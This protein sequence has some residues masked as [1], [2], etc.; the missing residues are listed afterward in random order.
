MSS[1][2]HY[3]CDIG[4]CCT[5]DCVAQFFLILPNHLFM[6]VLGLCCCVQAFSCC[7]EWGYSLLWCVGFLLFVAK[8][9]LQVQLW[10]TQ[11]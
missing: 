5:G 1:S 9:G 8:H 2:G 10:G 4:L 11:V 7:G 3:G 6:A